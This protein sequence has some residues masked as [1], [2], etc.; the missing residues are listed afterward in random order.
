MLE[1]LILLG[2]FEVSSFKLEI[3]LMKKLI[4]ALLIAIT[5]AFTSH[6]N[7]SNG[8]IALNYTNPNILV[9]VDTNT[10]KILVYSVSDKSGLSLK[11][12]RE[13][14]GALTAPSFFTSKGLKAKDEKKEFEQFKK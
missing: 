12:V 4:F 8:I 14:D 5:F 11:E 7:E 9:L 10:K 6:A 13:F 3:S 2:K 1:L